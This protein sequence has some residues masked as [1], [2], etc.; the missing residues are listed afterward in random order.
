MAYETGTSNDPQDFYTKLETFLT[1]NATLV[2]ANQQW[3]KVWTGTSDPTEKVFRATGLSGADTIYVGMRLV[4]RAGADEAYIEFHGMTGYISSAIDMAG[5]VNVTPQAVRSFLDF[6]PFTYWFTA[7]G[8]R[9]ALAWKISTVYQTAYAGFILPL[10]L[11]TTYPNPV[12]IGGMSGGLQLLGPTDFAP[13]DWRSQD[14]DHRWY[15]QPS[16]QTAGATVYGSSAWLLSPTVNWLKGDAWRDGAAYFQFHPY[17]TIETSNYSALDAD[18]QSE[19]RGA[20]SDLFG[21]HQWLH[22]VTALAANTQSTFGQLDGVYHCKGIRQSAES[23][24]TIGGVDH[25]VIQNAF[26]TGRLGYAALRLE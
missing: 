11:P 10:V 23:I 26:R 15:L 19:L 22:P 12:L 6:S 17:S 20:I 16:P 2:A 14:T 8:R 5:H 24:V 21:G 4:E 7:N 1:T 18:G 9:F 3:T 13:Y 25:L